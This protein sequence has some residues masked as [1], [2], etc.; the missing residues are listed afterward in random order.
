M[1]NMTIPGL[2]LTEPSILIMTIR[3]ESE[4]TGG[5]TIIL[6]IGPFTMWNQGGVIEMSSGPVSSGASVT[7][8]RDVIIAGM[9]YIAELRLWKT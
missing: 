4:D 9:A 6:L 8:D 5:R 7:I 1:W 2:S 3:T